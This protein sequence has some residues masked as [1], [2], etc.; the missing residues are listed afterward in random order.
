[1]T[2][3]IYQAVRNRETAQR[4][5]VCTSLAEWA[6]MPEMR[7]TPHIR[8]DE[9]AAEISNWSDVQNGMVYVDPHSQGHGK[10]G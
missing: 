9:I 8:I 5:P 10:S 7:G 2:S 3:R 4:V 6:R 1:M